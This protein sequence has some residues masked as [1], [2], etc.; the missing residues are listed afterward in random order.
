VVAQRLID[1]W[2]VDDTLPRD[3]LS[4]LLAKLPEYLT[5]RYENDEWNFSR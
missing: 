2:Q 1:A 5:M 3:A 4:G